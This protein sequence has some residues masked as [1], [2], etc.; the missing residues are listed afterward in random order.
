MDM[1]RRVN[2]SVYVLLF[3]C[4]LGLSNVIF[5]NDQRLKPLLNGAVELHRNSISEKQMVIYNRRFSNLESVLGNT[6]T[7]LTVV[8]RSES[9][10]DV[11]SIAVCELQA[12]DCSSDEILNLI[13]NLEPFSDEN[14]GY[15]SLE[16]S[17]D[18]VIKQVIFLDESD[19]YQNERSILAFRAF[20]KQ[21]LSRQV[22]S[23]KPIPKWWTDG[24][25][26]YLTK[27]LVASMFLGEP[28]GDFH[29]RISR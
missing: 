1:T 27:T 4:L 25:E 3:L 8:K 12:N 28:F 20:F 18:N 21:F 6:Q 23:A 19:A 14:T 17:V 29:N 7:Y 24:Q 10:A 5:A 11:A 16:L 13:S 15:R 26:E 22:R 9:I 2:I